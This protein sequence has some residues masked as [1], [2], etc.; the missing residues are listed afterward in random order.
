MEFIELYV[1]DFNNIKNILETNDDTTVDMV[2]SF[3]LRVKIMNEDDSTE[4]FI[5]S[6]YPKNLVI[7]RV[8]VNNRRK[9]VFTKVLNELKKIAKENGF[10]RIIVES[11]ITNE[12]AK[13]CIKNG[14]KAYS[15]YMH[16]FKPL[17]GIQIG[18]DYVMEVQ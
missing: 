12:M 18:C 2:R 9:G 10:E 17:E 14:L 5:A 15:N 1:S 13:C 11:V 8:S 16:P 4:L 3:K 7:Q 6:Y